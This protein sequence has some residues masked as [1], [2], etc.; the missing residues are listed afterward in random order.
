MN[1]FKVYPLLSHDSLDLAFR[2]ETT[3]FGREEGG[4]KE[5]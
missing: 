5:V 1:Y 4:T 3:N 2:A